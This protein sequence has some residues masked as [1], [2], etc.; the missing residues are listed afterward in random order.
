MSEPRR[1]S[2][3][4]VA[5]IRDGGTRNA[6]LGVVLALAQGSDIPKQRARC[7]SVLGLLQKA[8]DRVRI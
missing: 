6:K 2:C 1:H 8:S 5:S 3:H 4:S 7:Y